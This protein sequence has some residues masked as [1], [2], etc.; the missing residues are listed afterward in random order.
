M[1][2]V[3]R[4]RSEIGTLFLGKFCAL[5]LRREVAGSSPDEVIDFFVSIY[6]TIPAASWPWGLLSL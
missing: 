6:L 5:W 3:V 1:V 2:E 4:Y